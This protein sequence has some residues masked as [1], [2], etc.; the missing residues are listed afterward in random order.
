MTSNNSKVLY[1]SKTED[2]VKMME[3]SNISSAFSADTDLFS[4]NNKF[5]FSAEKTSFMRKNN[6]YSFQINENNYYNY[7]KIYNYQENKINQISGFYSEEDNKILYL[8]KKGNDSI[9]YFIIDYKE[10]IFTF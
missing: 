8:Y 5:I 10:K 2:T 7:F 6:I 3:A 4:Y 9:K 1:L